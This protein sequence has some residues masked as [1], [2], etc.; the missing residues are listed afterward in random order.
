MDRDYEPRRRNRGVEFIKKNSKPLLIIVAI[1][2]AVIVA[3]VLITN[4]A[5]KQG[6]DASFL[7]TRDVIKIGLRTDIDGFGGVDEN[8]NLIG[9]DREYIDAVLKELVGGQEKMYEYYPITSQDA[10]GE[11]KYGNID[12]ALGLLTDGENVAKTKGFNLTQPYYTDDVVAV[13]RADSRVQSVPE[14]EATT[15]GVINTAMS[16]DDL[17]GYLNSKKLG[18]EVVR[19]S[20]YESAMLDLEAGRIPAV[21]MPKAVSRQF[22]EAGYRIL[23]EPLYTVGYCIMLPTGQSAVETEMNKVI[24]RFKENGTT[25]ALEEKWGV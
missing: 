4:L 14:I 18:F 15:I 19:Y 22:E 11:I 6:F 12:M 21:V 23:A 7:A 5:T 8:G 16:V 25:L 24:D 17:K 20:D 2:A 9:F 13:M 3:A 1:V 10:A